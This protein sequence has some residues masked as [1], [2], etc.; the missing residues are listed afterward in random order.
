MLGILLPLLMGAATPTA[1]D[2]TLPRATVFYGDL[3]LA[4]A[5]GQERF[6]R[7]IQTAAVQMCGD[8]S[9]RDLRQQRGVAQCHAAAMDSA[10][11][12]FETAVNH[13][14]TATRLA[15]TAPAVFASK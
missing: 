7:R 6:A 10:K 15:S 11:A 12:Q 1:A 14:R 9:I 2:D 3:N 5:S 13:A 8:A 4:S